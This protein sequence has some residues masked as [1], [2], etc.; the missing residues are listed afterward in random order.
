VLQRKDHT[1]PDTHP[2][3]LG[4]YVIGLGNYVTVNPSQLGNYLIVHT[5]VPVVAA[6][7]DA[8]GAGLA[9]TTCRCDARLR[10][11]WAADGPAPGAAAC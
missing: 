3:A 11:S 10:R 8:A 5:D 6:P 9:A 1:K 7:A 4:N 2:V